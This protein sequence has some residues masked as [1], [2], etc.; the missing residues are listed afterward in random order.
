MNSMKTS[1]NPHHQ[2]VSQAWSLK[3]LLQGLLDELAD[4]TANLFQV[5][6]IWKSQTARQEKLIVNQ[7]GLHELLQTAHIPPL[8]LLS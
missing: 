5:S 2:I 3:I 4:N 6:L 1:D 7:I 8:E